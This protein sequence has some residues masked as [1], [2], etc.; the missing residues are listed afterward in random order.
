[1]KSENT[2]NITKSI[3]PFL[4]FGWS[5]SFYN[6][7]KESISNKIKTDSQIFNQK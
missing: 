2:N 6:S 1:M 4:G 3:N 5:S 7:R